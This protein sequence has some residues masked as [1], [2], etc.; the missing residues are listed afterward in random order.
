MFQYT[1]LLGFFLKILPLY[2]Y[3]FQIDPCKCYMKKKHPPLSVI[4]SIGWKKWL[5]FCAKE[6]QL[7]SFKL[8]SK[9]LKFTCKIRDTIQPTPLSVVC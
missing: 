2:R 6:S 1:I 5:T 8:E 9:S 4:S 7:Q 3:F